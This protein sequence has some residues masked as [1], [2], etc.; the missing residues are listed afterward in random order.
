MRALLTRKIGR[1]EHVWLRKEEEDERERGMLRS[2]LEEMKKGHARTPVEK[3]AEGSAETE[4]GILTR[5]DRK[6]KELITRTELV[7]RVSRNV[8][9]NEEE[10]KRMKWELDGMRFPAGRVGEGGDREGDAGGVANRVP[11]GIG[12]RGFVCFFFA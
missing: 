11:Q 8:H 4:G 5:M 7:G 6:E 10:L 2:F 3:L 12:Y 1:N 9:E